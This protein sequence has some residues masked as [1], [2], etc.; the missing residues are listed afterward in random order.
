M[1]YSLFYFLQHPL[2]IAAGNRLP[3]TS[4]SITCLAGGEK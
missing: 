2:L 4:K 3:D 1:R